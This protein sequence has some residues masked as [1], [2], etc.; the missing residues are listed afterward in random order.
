MVPRIT[1]TMRIVCVRITALDWLKKKKSVLLNDQAFLLQEYFH[2]L[3]CQANAKD[4]EGRSVISTPGTVIGNHPN[5]VTTKEI[6]CVW[7]V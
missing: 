2:Y 7:V 6:Q 1:V 4:R 3:L 5:A